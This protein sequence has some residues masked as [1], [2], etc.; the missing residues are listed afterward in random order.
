M[1]TRRT[2]KSD[3]A[4]STRDEQRASAKRRRRI[5]IWK[6]GRIIVVFS[7]L[8]VLSYLDRN[9]FL[10]AKP[11]DFGRYNGVTSQVVRVIDG[12]T[13]VVDLPDK[14]NRTPTTQIRVWGI[15]C[16]QSASPASPH[17]RP[18]RPVEPFADAATAFTR[19]L[20]RGRT[21]RLKLEPDRPRGM[22][23][24]VLAHV[25]LVGESPDAYESDPDAPHFDTNLAAELLR[26][27]F[28]R[29]DHRWHHALLSYYQ[30][31]ETIARQRQ[32]GIWKPVAEETNSDESPN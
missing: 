14:V 26:S 21:V 32:I 19:Q 6:Y 17:G 12:D 25:I 31:L 4:I 24:G 5:R 15:D 10:L 29:E 11:S 30:R 3:N 2:Q 23:G 27:G 9:G 18:A 20:I 22:F 8:A 28:A 16:P 13:I 7:I 1:P